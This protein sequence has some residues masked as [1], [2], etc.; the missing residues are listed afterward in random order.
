MA[1]GSDPVIQAIVSISLLLL[2][3]K[4]LGELFDRLHLPAVL[5]ELGAGVILG[6]LYFGGLVQIPPGIVE[7]NDV[8]LAFGQVGGIVLLFIAGLEMPFRDFVRGGLASFTTGALG[9]ILPFAGGFFLFAALRF[10]FRSGL[11]IGAALTATS[12]AISVQ[13]LR[14]VGRL[15]SPEGRLVIGAAVVDD[16]LAIAVL[17]IVVS[18]V[19]GAPAVSSLFD[20]IVVVGTVLFLFGI[21]L[22]LAV[23]VSPRLTQSK[24]WRTKGSVE[25]VA[26]AFLFGLAALAGIIGLSPV[27]GAFA[28]GM[29]IAGANIASRMREYVEKLE[30][31]FRPLFFAVVGSQVSLSGFT[32]LAALTG[33]AVIGV[34][35]VTKLIGCGLPALF[36]L[37][38]NTAAR[39]VGIAMMSRGE[40]GLIIAGLAVTSRLVSSE[41]HA[42]VVLM[43]VVTTVITPV[44]LKREVSA[45][46]R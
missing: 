3:A 11:I 25:T 15:N 33:V 18:L 40:V 39:T 37:K 4:L 35:M 20:V 1:L 41:I 17:S 36:F 31:I 12:I 21:L 43:V 30:L 2:G 22:G 46:A 13:T 16:V 34:A 24:I 32:P 42:I 10:D 14:E 28:A 8:V 19:T 38:S 45:A 26:T 7:V 23:L 44:W 5:G 6:P 27:V 29:G 9:V